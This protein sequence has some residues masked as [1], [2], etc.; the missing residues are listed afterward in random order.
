MS[1]LPRSAR[2]DPWRYG[3]KNHAKQSY[4]SQTARRH[5]GAMMVVPLLQGLAVVGIR[6]PRCILTPDVILQQLPA[7]S[8]HRRQTIFLAFYLL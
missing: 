7:D 2:E 6:I 5:H 3:K 4:K 1:E 8:D